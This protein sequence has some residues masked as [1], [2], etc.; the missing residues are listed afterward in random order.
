[1]AGIEK[2]Y[3]FENNQDK[4]VLISVPNRYWVHIAVV[5]CLILLSHDTRYK[6]RIIFPKKRPYEHNLN[7]IIN[8]F[9]KEDFHYWLSI[10]VDNPPLNNPLDLV[11]WEKDIIGLPTP[12][13]HY[14]AEKKGERPVY[15]NAYDYDEK[16]DAYREHQ[17]RE[18]LQKVDA[19]GT[20]CFLIARRVF[21]NKKMRMGA[22]LRQWHQDG[23][24][25]KGN[26]HS[27]CERARG[28]GF[29]IYTH[30]DYP[31]EHYQ[32]LPLNEVVAAF[33]N[34]YEKD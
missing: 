13:W 31:C 22:F 33:R 14:T 4:R 32:N 9:M 5:R 2:K 24:V 23:T 27:F 10:D 6:T 3:E 17:E 25:H 26:D 18:G 30:Y 34:M 8:R 15:W 21:E 11:K 20:G 1:M 16:L 12:I 7:H 19:I 29:K 28:Q